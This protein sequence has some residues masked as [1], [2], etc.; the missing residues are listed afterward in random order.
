M[1]LYCTNTE[2]PIPFNRPVNSEVFKQVLTFCNLD[3]SKPFLTII[4]KRVEKQIRRFARISTEEKLKP[5][6]TVKDAAGYL[7]QK[8]FK[9]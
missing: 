1:L 5:F 9:N 7:A 2:T 6:L 3:H 8:G 4:G